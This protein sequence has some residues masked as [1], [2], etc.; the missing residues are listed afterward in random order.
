MPLDFCNFSND[1]HFASGSILS[2]KTGGDIDCMC[3]LDGGNDD[4][5]DCRDFFSLSCFMM[6]Y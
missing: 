6:S 1:F 5:E 3:D 4:D 2:C